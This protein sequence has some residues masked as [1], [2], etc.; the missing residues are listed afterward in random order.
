MRFFKFRVGIMAC[1]L[2]FAW[3]FGQASAAEMTWASKCSSFGELKP[4]QNP[5]DQHINC[6]LTNAAIE[7]N[8]PPEV[9]KAVAEQES[10]GW[11]QFN[12]D[13]TPLESLDGGIGIMQITNQ[14]DYAQ[15]LK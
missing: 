10:G 15:E 13:G 3:S 7:A 11:K 6:L 4:N 14:S 2:F 1:L 8:I 12:E 9:V 5:T